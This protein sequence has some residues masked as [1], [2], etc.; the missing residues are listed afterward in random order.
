MLNV[1][2]CPVVVVVVL[3][4]VNV[5]P[6]LFVHKSPWELCQPSPHSFRG[7]DFRES[8]DI[9][10]DSTCVELRDGLRVKDHMR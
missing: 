7:Q 10:C 2:T 1:G 4:T 6:V 8:V 9:L 3:V 5:T